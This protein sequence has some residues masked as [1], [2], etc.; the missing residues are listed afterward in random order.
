MIHLTVLPCALQFWSFMRS[1][2]PKF[3][4]SLACRDKRI[5]RTIHC[6]L[7]HTSATAVRRG[8]EGGAEWEAPLTGGVPFIL[9]CSGE[10]DAGAKQP[11]IR[12]ILQTVVRRSIR[13]GQFELRPYICLSSTPPHQNA[14][15]QTQPDRYRQLAQDGDRRRELLLCVPAGVCCAPPPP[16]P[17]PPPTSQN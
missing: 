1:R 6:I 2:I 12:E 14:D 9:T 4:C 13:P 5:Q 16:P 10:C 11:H 7:N 15:R 3:H 17:P 8:S